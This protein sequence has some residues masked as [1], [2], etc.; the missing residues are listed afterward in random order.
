VD[1]G[2][3]GISDQDDLPELS[4]RSQ[5]MRRMQKR[6]GKLHHGV[7]ED[8]GCIG[9]DEEKKEVSKIPEN[10]TPEQIPEV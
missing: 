5:L 2:E 1:N 3:D 8:E 9:E 7:G 10:T 6:E 4:A